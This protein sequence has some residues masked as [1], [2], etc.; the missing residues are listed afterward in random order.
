MRAFTPL[1]M[2][3]TTA[4]VTTSCIA[5]EVNGRYPL[6]QADVEQIKRLVRWRFDIDKPITSIGG[7]RPNHAI[8][9]AGEAHHAGESFLEVPLE[10]RDGQWHLSPKSQWQRITLT[11]D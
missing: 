2:L 9:M 5:P 11:S 7:D 6:N 3:C 10:K 8:V 4:I 1:M